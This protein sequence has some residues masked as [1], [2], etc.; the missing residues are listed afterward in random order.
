MTSHIT[1]HFTWGEAACNHCGWLAPRSVVIATADWLEEIRTLL[2]DQPMHV[3][4]WCRCEAW[5]RRVGGAAESQHLR[6]TAV[7]FTLKHRTPRQVQA[8]LRRHWGEGKLIRGLGQYAGFTH[9]DR[10]EGA[11][12]IWRG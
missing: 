12:A 7:D 10:R 3:H 5:N 9:V 6:G 2:G 4:S 8:I 1:E 11:A